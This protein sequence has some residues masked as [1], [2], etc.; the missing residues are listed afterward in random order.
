MFILVSFYIWDWC[1][2]GRDF[3]FNGCVRKQW[4]SQTLNLYRLLFVFALNLKWFKRNGF[5]LTDFISFLI[6]LSRWLNLT[7][8]DFLVLV[9]RF[10][11][12]S[13]HIIGLP[14]CSFFLL[15]FFLSQ[16]FLQLSLCV[17]MF[18]C[19]LYIAANFLIS[20]IIQ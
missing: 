5:F 14:K 17:C 6:I 12:N 9:V 10:P 18:V 4:Q 11:L 15:P 8:I 3:G 19:I 20:H 7:P 16:S 13:I 2:A 1:T